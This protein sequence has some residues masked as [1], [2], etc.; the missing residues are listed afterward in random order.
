MNQKNLTNMQTL[1]IVESHTGGEPTRVVID[2][3]FDLST[4]SMA[5][6]VLRVQGLD[7]AEHLS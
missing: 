2:G 1:E 5:E 4:G 6:K 7:T 3:S